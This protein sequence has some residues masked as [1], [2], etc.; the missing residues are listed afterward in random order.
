ME[1]IKELLK[2]RHPLINFDSINFNKVSINKDNI[3]EMSGQELIESF[4]DITTKQIY[5]EL[6]LQ[7]SFILPTA[8]QTF[9][10]KLAEIYNQY[11]VDFIHNIYESYYIQKF[12]DDAN[13]I[14]RRAMNLRGVF[15]N[16][17]FSQELSNY[18][19]EAF[20]TYIYG[21]HNASVILLRSILEQILKEKFSINIGTFGVINNDCYRKGLITREIYDNNKKVNEK[22]RIAVHNIAIGRTISERENKFLIEVT[23]KNLRLFLT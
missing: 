20:M 8:D 14:V 9:K 10:D 4:Q 23:Q 19:R 2:A 7:E 1:E 16:N 18:C 21:L 12:V 15:Y 3:E 6:K 17:L 22:A 11:D 5:L 13:N